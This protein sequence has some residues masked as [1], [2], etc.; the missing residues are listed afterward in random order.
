MAAC[1]N[2]S[3]RGAVGGASAGLALPASLPAS[4]PLAASRR[5]AAGGGG[6]DFIV[7]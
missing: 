1:A 7:S 3:A 2:R 5:F 6:Y 4:L